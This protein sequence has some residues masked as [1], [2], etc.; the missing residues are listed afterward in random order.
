M[1]VQPFTAERDLPADRRQH[2]LDLLVAHRPDGREAADLE[3]RSSM[4]QDRS[5]AK[6]SRT[7]GYYIIHQDN[8]A[9]S[10]RKAV[11][12]DGSHMVEWTGTRSSRSL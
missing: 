5:A 2:G 12:C 4:H 1:A 8:A 7:A 3:G 9:D 10:K 11:G 6:K